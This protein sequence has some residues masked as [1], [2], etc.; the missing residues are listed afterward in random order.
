MHKEPKVYLVTGATSGIGLDL[1]KKILLNKNYV[2]CC[3]RSFEEL[4]NFVKKKKLNSFYQKIKTDF[5]QLDN[6]KFFNKIKKVNFIVNAA[7]FVEHNLIKFF[8]IK[9][10]LKLINV[11]LIFPIS[12]VSELYKKDKIADNGKIVF[13]SSLLNGKKTRIGALGYGV[14]K[15]GIDASVRSFALEMA[16]KNICVNAV[17]P[18]MVN[19]DMIK[20]IKMLSKHLIAI[21]KKKYPLEQRYVKI[22]EVSNLVMYLLSKKSDFITGQTIVL[23]GG[24]SLT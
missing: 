1:T 22:S 16:K 7:G 6:L 19:T 15:S 24:F 2:I 10:F 13:I 11:N 20:N 4:D 18:G 14:A 3:G 8:K 17:A 23:D 5:S 12:L 21:D 9:T